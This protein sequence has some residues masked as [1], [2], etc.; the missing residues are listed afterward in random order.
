MN[1]TDLLRANR[2]VTILEM[3]MALAISAALI[4]FTIGTGSGKERRE[5][6]AFSVDQVREIEQA[7]REY[8]RYDTPLL[9][10]ES[11]FNDT[12]E[13]TEPLD[14]SVWQFNGTTRQYE[15]IAD[16]SVVGRLYGNFAYGSVNTGQRAPRW[17]QSAQR[18]P[19][20]IQRLVTDS[21]LPV[22]SPIAGG[23]A[24]NESPWGTTMR[25]EQSEPLAGSEEGWQWARRGLVIVIPTTSEQA[26]LAL[27]T[28]LGI[29]A[30]V[31]DVPGE[32]NATVR[33]AIINPI[34]VPSYRGLSSLAVQRSGTS[35]LSADME[36]GGFG[37]NGLGRPNVL[38]I[39]NRELTGFPTGQL[40]VTHDLATAYADGIGLRGGNYPYFF[41]ATPAIRLFF[42]EPFSYKITAADPSTYNAR[43]ERAIFEGPRAGQSFTHLVNGINV[44]G[45]VVCDSY[46]P[47]RGASV[48]S[49]R[50]SVKNVA[51]NHLIKSWN[52]GGTPASLGSSD[53]RVKE[54]IQQVSG[55][56]ALRQVH[57]V[58]AVLDPVTHAPMLD[59]EA[60]RAVPG[61]HAE[62]GWED[63]HRGRE[64]SVVLWQ[65]YGELLRRHDQFLT[66]LKSEVSQTEAVMVATDAKAP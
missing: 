6:V 13:F 49:R 63:E 51:A 55:E 35:I 17:R 10:R 20:S 54:N 48:T 66:T 61:L 50:T 33:Y 23:Y 36:A 34:Q 57:R 4:A 62:R 3:V 56:Y 7:A 12:T 18:W 30:A 45:P 16:S 19:E 31:S 60:V 44:T 22:A 39:E 15:Q 11:F 5:R 38:R 9:Y 42:N 29:Q 41:V 2:G 58:P 28:Q 26:A 64:A 52:P 59:P 37:L 47:Y 46:D 27:A 21:Y 65:A 43:P 14:T 8:W 40:T 25:L 53:L 24:W 1:R 32:G